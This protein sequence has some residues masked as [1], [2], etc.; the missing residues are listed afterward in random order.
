MNKFY[1]GYNYNYVFFIK[2]LG[3]LYR[4]A[5]LFYTFPKVQIAVI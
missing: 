2:I 1:Q 4:K 3:S 5:S